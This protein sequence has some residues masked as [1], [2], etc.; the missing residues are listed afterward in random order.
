MHTTPTTT[1]M[2]TTMPLGLPLGH[3]VTVALYSYMHEHFNSPTIAIE[4]IRCWLKCSELI[5]IYITGNGNQSEMLH[6]FTKNFSIHRFFIC[7]FLIIISSC[8]ILF[9][10]DLCECVYECL[11][12]WWFSNSNHTQ[13]KPNTMNPLIH[14]NTQKS[15]NSTKM[16]TGWTFRTCKVR[17]KHP[18]RTIFAKMQHKMYNAPQTD[19]H[20]N[21]NIEVEH[22]TLMI[23][24]ALIG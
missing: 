21:I 17:A 7:S 13:A 11:C 20:K 3:S 23:Y 22:Q 18:N 2:M 12:A 8:S 1:T 10:L 4:I 6:C 19:T 9:W 24:S 15:F 16:K 14:K 5:Y